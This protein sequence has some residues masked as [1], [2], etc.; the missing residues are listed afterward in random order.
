MEHLLRNK[1]LSNKQYGFVHG[2]S[3]LLNMLHQWTE[4]L[5]SGGQIDVI[6]TDY[7]K[8]FD[9]VPHRRLINKVASFGLPSMITEWI[10]V[11]LS[12]RQYKVR[13]NSK[14]SRWYS[15]LVCCICMMYVFCAAFYA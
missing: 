3:T 15:V 13:I 14:F 7:E 6:Y 9:K 11:F 4:E 8:A 12:D 2:R 10:K 1:Y 5:K